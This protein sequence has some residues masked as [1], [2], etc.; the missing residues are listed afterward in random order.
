[1][2]DLLLFDKYDPSL[3]SR[4]DV[5]TRDALGALGVDAEVGEVN[6]LE[7]HPSLFFD[8]VR[9]RGYRFNE[10]A[11]TWYLWGKKEAVLL[12][13]QSGKR[14]GER[15]A[16]TPE[17]FVEMMS[18]NIVGLPVSLA[19]DDYLQFE[20]ESYA[21][22]RDDA[23][24]KYGRIR[25]RGLK[26]LRKDFLGLSFDVG[27]FSRDVVSYNSYRSPPFP[28]ESVVRCDAGWRRRE[29]YSSEENS[30]ANFNQLIR[31]QQLHRCGALAEIDAEYRSI[32]STVADLGAAASS[33]RLAFVSLIVALVSFG[34]ALTA[35]LLTKIDSEN[36]LNW[37]I[38]AWQVLAH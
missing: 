26:T 28:L 21:R 23:M 4:P 25:R 5:E 22:L 9:Y 3:G 24:R 17:T 35:V 11:P 20:I 7:H 27:N 13:R 19:I 37:L 15:E 8:T 36:Y 30:V 33:I 32:L 29:V 10:T 2:V 38:H 31:N 12:N 34:V 14:S 16:L 18:Y 6:Y 1:L